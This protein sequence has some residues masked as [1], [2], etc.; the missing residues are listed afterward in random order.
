MATMI[1]RMFYS[2]SLRL[3]RLIAQLV[4]I[5]DANGRLIKK[6]VMG[7]EV[8]LTLRI[9][10]RLIWRILTARESVSRL[11]RKTKCLSKKGCVFVVNYFCFSSI[12]T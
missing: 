9:W 12:G 6:E 3:G 2:V 4:K 10:R 1:T 8:T 7:V 5:R 11:V